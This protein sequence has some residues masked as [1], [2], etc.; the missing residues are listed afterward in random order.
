MAHLL[1]AQ[2]YQI[3]TV[4]DGKDG[5]YYAQSGQY[6]A[7]ILDVMLPSLNGFQLAATLRKRGIATPILMLTARDDVHDKVRGLDSGAD[8]YLTKPFTQEELL[9]RIR[10]L[11]RRPAGVLMDEI[12]FA[13][14]LLQ[15]KNAT[16]ICGDKQVRLSQKEL[17]VMKIL[18]SC[19]GELISKT[20]LITRVWGADSDAMDNNVEAYVSFLRKKLFYLGSH[21]QISTQR[22]LGY[23][24]EDIQ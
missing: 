10:A 14:I 17:E 9:A 15:Q 1:Q 6:D 4:C 23:L 3:D 13:D 21:V 7:L 5:L 20:D 22:R 12:S 8:D 18:L 24:L 16:L 2:K 11:L 19:P